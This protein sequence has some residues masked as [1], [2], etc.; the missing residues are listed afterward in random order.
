M[1]GILARFKI[2]PGKEDAAFA[3]FRDTAA[4]VQAAEPGTLVYLFFRTKTD[5]QEIVVFEVYADADARKTHN[6]SEIMKATHAKL[7]EVIDMQSIKLEG[8]DSSVIGF[9][10]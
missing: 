8:L 5:P 4:K 1:T 10:R 6:T 7:P 3:L 2:Q 9:E